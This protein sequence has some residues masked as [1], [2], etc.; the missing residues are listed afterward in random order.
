M[1]IG[2]ARKSLWIET[3]LRPCM[4]LI[5][6]VR[7]V[8]ACGSKHADPHLDNSH[9]EVRLV[10]ACGSKH[11]QNISSSFRVAVRLVR[12]CGSKRYNRCNKPKYRGQARESLWIETY[13]P[14]RN[15]HMV[16]GQARKSLWIETDTA[17][18][19]YQTTIGQARKSLWIETSQTAF[20]PSQSLVRLV[21]AC[22]SKLL[23][24][25]IP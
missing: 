2:Q 3:T 22:G 23:G 24:R 15:V 4:D 25:M 21:R 8:R 17:A 18:I 1:C 19:G 14:C 5:H 7:L 10:R 11:P 13:L 20:K 6:G 16:Y 12:A 9:A